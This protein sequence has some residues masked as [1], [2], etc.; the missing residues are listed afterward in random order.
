M[1]ETAKALYNKVP[2]AGAVD[3]GEKFNDL[4]TSLANFVYRNRNRLGCSRRSMV[5]PPA[6][7]TSAYTSRA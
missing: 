4:T 5:A 2:I 3:V 1:P 7:F 6:I